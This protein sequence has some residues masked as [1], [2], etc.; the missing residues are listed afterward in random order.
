MNKR[1]CGTLN[2]YINSEVNSPA[3]S[4]INEILTRDEA[5]N[6]PL[7]TVIISMLI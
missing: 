5:N 4:T 1:E 3:P 6:F 2:L 7:I